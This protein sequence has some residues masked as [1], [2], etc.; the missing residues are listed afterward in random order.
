MTDQGELRSVVIHLAE[1][2]S[3]DKAA[4]QRLEQLGATAPAHY[5]QLLSLSADASVPHSAR[6]LAA[7][8]LKNGIDRHWRKTSKSTLHADVKASI[9]SQLLS[10]VCE[11]SPKLS[12]VYAEATA[13]IAQID[14]PHDWPDVVP[15]L[16]GTLESALSST[17]TSSLSELSRLHSAQQHCLYTLHRVVKAMYSVKTMRV[18]HVLYQMAPQ[19][20]QHMSSI[21]SSRIHSFLASFPSP[22][23][24]TSVAS[25]SDAAH[26]ES[27]D[28]SIQLA[29]LALKILRRLIVNGFPERDDYVRIDPT[30]A[31]SGNGAVVAAPEFYKPFEKVQACADLSASL[32]ECLQKMLEIRSASA[33]NSLVDRIFKATTKIA[34]TIGKIYTDLI[35]SRAVN[36][37]VSPGSFDVVRFYWSLVANGSSEGVPNIRGDSDEFVERVLLQGLRIIRGV[38]KNPQFTILP[39]DRHPRTEEVAH[40]ISTQLMTPDFVRTVAQTL[41]T[42]YLIYNSEELE[43]WTESPEEFVADEEA[44]QWEFSLRLCSQKLLMDLVNK[45]R[46][47]LAPMLLSMLQ[48]VAE[49]G[50]TSDTSAIRLKDAVYSSVAFCSYDLYDYVEFDNWFETRLLPEST[51]QLPPNS[52]PLW[53]VIRRSVALLVSH[54]IAVKSAPTMRP[55]FYRLLIHLASPSNEPDMVVRLSA[56]SVLRVVL[57]EGLLTDAAVF[58]PF[59]QNCVLVLVQIVG[60]AEE[61]DTKVSGLTTLK[62]VIYMMGTKIA[63]FVQTITEQLP[64]LWESSFDQIMF[65]TA[66]LLVLSTLVRALQEQSIMLHQLVL[67]AIQNTLM[68]SD[69]SQQQHFLE[70]S[71]DLWVATLQ[72]T[73]SLT[74]ELVSLYACLGDL[75]ELGS[76]ENLKVVLRLLEAYFVLDAGSFSQHPGTL[77]LFSK[78]S[79]YLVDLKIEATKHIART[80]M[81]VVRSSLQSN[82]V[83][84]IQRQFIESKLLATLVT[85][86]L[87]SS[88]KGIVDHVVAD[89]TT[90]VSLFVVWDVAF[91]VNFL[92]EF[93]VVVA[94]KGASVLPECLDVWNRVYDA[95]TYPKQRKS[96]GMALATLVG[97][98]NPDVMG[99]IQAIFGSLAG[100]L[101]EVHGMNS[102]DARLHWCESIRSS[103]HSLGED[104]EESPDRKRRALLESQDPIAITDLKVFVR[105]KLQACEAAIGGQQWGLMVQ[106]VDADVSR[107][108]FQKKNELNFGNERTDTPSASHQPGRIAAVCSSP[109]RYSP[110]SVP[111]H[112]RCANPGSVSTTT[113]ALD[114]LR[115]LLM[116][117]MAIDHAKGIFGSF[118]NTGH[119]QWFK[120]PDYNG[121]LAS[122]MTRFVTS[123][124][125]PGFFMLMGWGVTLFVDSRRRIGWTWERIFKHYALRGF[126]LLVF[127]ATTLL[128]VKGIIFAPITTVLFA[129]GINMFLASVF[130]WG[131]ETYTQKLQIS[132]GASSENI[133]KKLT[134]ALAAGYLALSAFFTVLPSLYTPTSE[135]ANDNFSTWY[136]VWFL[137]HENGN[138]VMSLYPPV[139]WIAPTLWGVGIGRIVKRV[140]WN[141]KQMSLYNLI[142]GAA[143]L[144]LGVALRYASNW[145]SINPELVHPPIRT[146]FISFFNNVKYPPSVVYTLITLSGNHIALGLF[147]LVN[148]ASFICREDSVLMVYGRSSLFFYVTHFYAYFAL[149]ALV[150]LVC[151]EG[152]SVGSG[153]LFWTF[154][155]VGLVAEY[156]ACRAY[157]EFKRGTDRDS[158]WRLF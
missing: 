38:V 80:L 124:C 50:P 33:A 73:P 148:P 107:E 59:V 158:V 139:A 78:L 61:F 143:M 19:L 26:I 79:A 57:S 121:N 18:K 112:R 32:T 147:Y 108:L 105:E 113:A 12:R 100:V 126:V 45:N 3:S 140:G 144:S 142:A 118:G 76:S 83:A 20:F 75:I 84:P 87:Q 86:I 15:S 82:H 56:V 41:M 34:L 150:L 37:I 35:T 120:M 97:T 16:L 91:V 131:E 155:G 122:F 67:P 1:S 36:F 88:A 98:A 60:E 21:F 68:G 151:G 7:L 39:P 5:A 31:K 85:E 8:Y 103:T 123:F 127:N 40:L 109:I 95:M 43:K 157:G 70:D 55:L 48:E 104:D 29:R 138:G 22:A 90:I 125:A 96:L 141:A 58:E 69:P 134:M 64:A 74:P 156:F 133:E 72:N 14:Y 101:S 129:L 65:R 2:R 44:D 53:K 11:E 153:G 115:G 47:V 23:T 30:S 24:P 51:A 132:L 6:L 9:R 135:H 52:N 154:Y 102:E 46:D 152:F 54:W 128:P 130:L 28:G 94:G 89:F 111:C 42:K 116:I 77:V 71:I 10:L 137:P 92:Q 49:V 114:L 63:P 119:E 145:T 27:L 117:L 13:K 66:I 110:E 136:L 62:E 99:R 106:S 25:I 149:H 146:S 93:G 81:I 4:E 17:A